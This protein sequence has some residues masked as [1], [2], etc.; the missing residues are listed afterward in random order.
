MKARFAALDVDKNGVISE[1]NVALLAKNLAVGTCTVV[2]GG[3]KF[4]NIKQTLTL[5][6]T[7]ILI[8]AVH[9]V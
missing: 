1:D 4:F 2:P 7:L 8:Q 3:A 6:L 9:T 5:T